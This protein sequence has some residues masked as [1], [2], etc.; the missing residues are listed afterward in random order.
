MSGGKP[1]G[2][3]IVCVGNSL[4]G[5]DAA[6]C[7][8]YEALASLPLPPRVRLL[9]L[10]LGG[11]NL[12]D[13]LEGEA[14]LIVVDA[15][16]LGAPPGTVHVLA[17][18]EIP[19]AGGAAVSVHGVGIREAITVGKMLFPDRMPCRI[20]LVGIEGQWFD[21]LG[22]SMSPEVSASLDQAVAEVLKL[23]AC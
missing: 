12:L 10:G 16:Q 2:A 4:A 5:D 18:D 6:G 23:I 14:T 7:A 22:E 11:M 9:L 17:W 1:D 8:V 20:V 19:A 21:C 15:V 3:V 13:D